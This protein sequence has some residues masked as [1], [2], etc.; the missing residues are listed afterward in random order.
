MRARP[1]I[2]HVVAGA[3]LVGGAVFAME[4]QQ[5]WMPGRYGDMT[6]VL[7][8]VAGW[9]IPWCVRANEPA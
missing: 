3:L 8:C 4:W 5:Q 6:Q 7:L 2:L 1:S 9:I